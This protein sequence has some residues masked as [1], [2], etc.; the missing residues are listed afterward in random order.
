MVYFQSVNEMIVQRSPKPEWLKVRLP[1]GSNF[2]HL[3]QLTRGLNLHT[4]CESARCPNIGECWE[5]GTATFMILGNTCT[6][7]CGFCAV[8]SGKPTEYDLQEPERVAR[9]VDALKLHYVVVTSVARDDVAD[10]GAQIF[11]DTIRAVRRVRPA[12]RV[13]V[14]IPDFKGSME[15]LKTVMD[16]GPYV[17]NHNIETVERLQKPVRRSARYEW[18]LGVLA[19]A[20]KLNPHIPTKS[21]IML[22]LGEAW[23]EVTQT[24]RDLRAVDCNFLTIGQYLRPTLEHLPVARYAP[25]GE[26]E[27][28]RRIGQEL[29][30]TNVESGPLVRSSYHAEKQN[31]SAVRPDWQP[32]TLSLGV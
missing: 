2:A 28:L 15:S 13:E 29:G 26:F 8:P 24:M 31:H 4:V 5:A 18:S 12:C 32:P 11:A 10:G 16:A 22:G 17:L 9:A 3:K 27:E 23:D 20:K 6:R 25:P 21:G 19:N 14:L 30:F 1:S 7:R